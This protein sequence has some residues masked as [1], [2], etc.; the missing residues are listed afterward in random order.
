M[1]LEEEVICGYKVS[2]KRKRVW[3]VQ[4][5][6]A[7][8]MDEICKKHAIKYFASDGTLLGCIRHNGF[9]PWDDDMDFVMLRDDYEKFLSVAPAELPEY[10]FLQDYYTEKNYF[11]GH[12]QLRDSRTTCLLKGGHAALANKKNCGIFIDIFPIDYLA[13]T[14][15]KRKK[16]ARKVW[17]YRLCCCRKID[18]NSVNASF[19]VRTLSTLYNACHGLDGTVRKALDPCRGKRPTGTLGV[20]TFAPGNE[21][22]VWNASAFTGGGIIISSMT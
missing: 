1:N 10:Y 6:L 5:E 7:K 3:A 11:S 21:S 8:K 2:E 16:Q 14:L 18:K 17:F 4:I 22:C 9:I 19:M 12:A 15:K 20:I 13:D